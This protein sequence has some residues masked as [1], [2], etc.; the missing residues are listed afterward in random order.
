MTIFSCRMC[1]DNPLDLWSQMWGGSSDAAKPGKTKKSS[2]PSRRVVG[3]FQRRTLEEIKACVKAWEQYAHPRAR[4]FFPTKEMLETVLEQL[5]RGIHRED[6]PVLGDDTKC[7]YWYGDVTKDDQQAAI[8]MVKPGETSE[9]ITYVNRV[10][11]FIFATDESFD[12]LMRLPKEP[13]KMSC[14][15]QLCVNLAHISL[16]VDSYCQPVSN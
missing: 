14:G 2:K 5:A 7:V 12:H 3:E 11:A 9:S 1:S 8:K 6:D 4:E 10:L 13:F 15:D 16:Q